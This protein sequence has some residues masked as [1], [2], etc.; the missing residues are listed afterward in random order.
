ME[1]DNH[2]FREEVT[3][4]PV[5]DHK[6][7]DIELDEN[8]GNT[9]V[10][11]DGFHVLETDSRNVTEERTKTLTYQGSPTLEQVTQVPLQHSMSSEPRTFSKQGI[12]S[13]RIPNH[14]S[15]SSPFVSSVK[16]YPVPQTFSRLP[17]DGNPL[18]SNLILRQQRD[19]RCIFSLF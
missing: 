4:M 14:G 19:F 7:P 8:N 11:V 3:M 6:E 15:D 12:P 10:S 17:Q 16:F 1:C 2:I 13:R 18:H 9:T 5:M